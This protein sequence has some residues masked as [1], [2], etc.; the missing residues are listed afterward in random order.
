[1]R[2]WGRGEMGMLLLARSQAEFE[3]GGCRRDEGVKLGGC[4]PAQKDLEGG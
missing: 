3:C 1:M 2:V 4:A